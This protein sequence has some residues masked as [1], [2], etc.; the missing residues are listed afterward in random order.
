MRV[1]FDKKAFLQ[2]LLELEQ[3]RKI[4]QVKKKYYLFNLQY[5]GKSNDA[6]ADEWY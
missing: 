3:M 1:L 5:F 2:I 4:H 6:E